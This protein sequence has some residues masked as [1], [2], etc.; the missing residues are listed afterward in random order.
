MTWSTQSTK[1]PQVRSTQNKKWTSLSFIQASIWPSILDI[2][3]MVGIS[4]GIKHFTLTL[5]FGIIEWFKNHCGPIT[6]III[7]IYPFKYRVI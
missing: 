5:S 4:I 1:L 2:N 3:L 7:I 6:I